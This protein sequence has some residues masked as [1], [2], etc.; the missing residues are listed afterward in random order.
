MVFQAFSFALV[1]LTAF[2][3]TGL[4]TKIS[5]QESGLSLLVEG[6]LANGAQV[7]IDYSSNSENVDWD[8]GSDGTIKMKDYCLDVTGS[9]FA[10]GTQ[11][12]LYQ[13]L[14]D[15]AQKWKVDG[16]L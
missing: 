15:E 13:C 9:N 16:R 6:D 8:I 5:L 1:F 3:G 11:L 2:V 14:G 12:E 4:A 10:N 7:M